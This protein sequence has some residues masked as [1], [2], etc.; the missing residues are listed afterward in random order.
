LKEPETFEDEYYHPNFEERMKR[1]EAI[2]KEFDEMKEE[3]V[4]E[5][6]LKFELPNGRTCIKNKW[7]FKIKLNG[8]FHARLV[9]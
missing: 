7:V 2:S 1:R 3:R 5:K 6:I 8:I 4:N 9:A